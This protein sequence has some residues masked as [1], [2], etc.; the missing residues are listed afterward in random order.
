[1]AFTDSYAQGEYIELHGES[2]IDDV[3]VYFDAIENDDA[4]M[5]YGTITEAGWDTYDSSGELVSEQE[6]SADQP[7]IHAFIYNEDA[8]HW[9]LAEYYPGEGDDLL[10]ELGIS[11][12]EPDLT[13]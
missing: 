2:H 11:D 12:T 6:G 5:V 13:R 10:E 9:Q 8:G 4:A 7:M 1:E 3:A